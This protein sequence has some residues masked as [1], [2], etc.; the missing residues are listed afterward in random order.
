MELEEHT[1]VIECISNDRLI[2][3]RI[4]TMKTV[5][6]LGLTLMAACITGLAA[7][8]TA[9]EPPALPATPAPVQELVYARSFTLEEGYQHTWRADKFQVTSGYLLV[10]KVDTDYVFPRQT[11][12]PVLFVG[13]RPPSR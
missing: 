11:E 10:L 12:E 4:E 6:Y 8:A 7:V 1:A 13:N 3:E 2:R 5:R 9:A